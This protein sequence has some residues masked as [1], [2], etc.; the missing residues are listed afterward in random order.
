MIKLEASAYAVPPPFVDILQKPGA[1]RKGTISQV[2][3]NRPEPCGVVVRVE[4]DWPP[5]T[6]SLVTYQ[7]RAVVADPSNVARRTAE[8]AEDED[9]D[10]LQSSLVPLAVVGRGEEEGGGEADAV[11]CC[12]CESVFC[13]A[14][15]VVIDAPCGLCISME[16]RPAKRP[17]T[18][19][20]A[21]E[22]GKT[23]FENHHK[24]V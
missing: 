16:G 10:L 2:P 11:V 15:L 9:D 22:A 5:I 23:T 20:S 4:W 18:T 12:A 7:E 13:G 19:R 8:D 14:P 24:R 1:L 3:A 6:G 21:S 17:T